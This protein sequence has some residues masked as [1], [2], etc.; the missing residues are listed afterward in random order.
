[1]AAWQQVLSRISGNAEHL[2]DILKERLAQRLDL[3]DP[4][5]IVAYRGYGTPEKLYL[6]GRVLED[7]GIVSA[8]EHDS[9][10]DNLLN[11]YRRFESDEVV[12][13]RVLARFQ[14]VEQ[15]V[16]TDDEGFFELWIEPKQPLPPTQTLYEIELE[17]IEPRHPERPYVRA[18]GHVIVPPPDAQFGVISDIDDTVMQTHATDLLRMARTVFLG[19]A[20]TRLPFKGV[21]ALYRAL[22]A[23]PDGRAL[24]PLFYVSSSPWN[25]YDLLYDF[26]ELQNIPVSALFLRDWGVS[27]EQV[28]PGRHRSHKLDAINKIMG[29]YEHLPF[30]LI[31]DSGQKDPEI[32]EEVV[33]LYPN[34]VLSVYIRNVTPDPARIAA[35][36]MLAERAVEVGSTLILAEDTFVVA[37]HAA[38]QGWI[39][40]DRLPE[41]MAE[42]ELDA[43]PP[44]FVEQMLGAEEQAEGPVV[45]IEGQDVAEMKEAI[46]TGAIESALEAG[47]QQRQGTPS[48]I[49]EGDIKRRT[50]EQERNG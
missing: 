7:E 5:K 2:F 23:G 44:N 15:E 12:G 24:N 14:G 46:E 37:E 17:L 39:A 33:R 42:K 43:S 26:F 47:D 6:K 1:M 25:L 10:W 19:S 34:R 11:M 30:I 20:R 35:I 13:A 4:L 28:G 36:R 40:A 9:I 21:A 32:Y 48:V 29:L 27:E 50:D 16:L 18:L 38:S 8:R 3:G 49:V 45:A 22:H 41:I 31:G